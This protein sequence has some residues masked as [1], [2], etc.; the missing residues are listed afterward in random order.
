MKFIPRKKLHVNLKGKWKIDLYL[1][2]FYHF[3]TFF[4][5]N[6]SIK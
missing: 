1:I 5:I 4:I 3:G 6:N 2:L